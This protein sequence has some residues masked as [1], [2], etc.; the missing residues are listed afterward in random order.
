MT[1]QHEGKGVSKWLDETLKV[2]LRNVC[3]KSIWESGD[4]CGSVSRSPTLSSGRVLCS[5][6]IVVEWNKTIVDGGKV[7]RKKQRSMT[8]PYYE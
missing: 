4:C 8:R 3:F 5:V 7:F 6:S 2:R 1:G